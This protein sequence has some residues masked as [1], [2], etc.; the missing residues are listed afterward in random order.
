MTEVVEVQ[1]F[2]FTIAGITS[3]KKIMALVDDHIYSKCAYIIGD[4]DENNKVE[5]DIISTKVEKPPQERQERILTAILN[6]L[7][8]EVNL[9]EE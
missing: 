3:D 4:A 2:D 9:T 1:N 5:Y 8:E 7:V 6:Y